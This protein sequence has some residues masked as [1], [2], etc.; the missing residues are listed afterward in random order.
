MA[1]PAFHPDQT[2]RV[3]TTPHIAPISAFIDIIRDRDDHGL[4]PYVPSHR[5][6]ID[7]RVISISRDRGRSTKP[8]TVSLGASSISAVQSG[9]LRRRVGVEDGTE[10]QHAF[11]QQLLFRGQAYLLKWVKGRFT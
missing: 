5:G 9:P 11:D 1:D 8:D 6:G 3:F 10:I 2:A 7:A 4:V